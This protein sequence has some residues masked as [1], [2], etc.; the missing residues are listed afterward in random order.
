MA[1]AFIDTLELFPRG[2]VFV[3]LG[4][5]IIVIA[6]IVQE[7]ITPYKIGEQLT[8]K[9]NVALALSI[10]GYYLGVIAVYI[11]ALF[12][13]FGSSVIADGNL[14]FTTDY[15]QGVLEVF[16]YALVGIAV[17]NISR[18]VVDKVVLYQF[19]TE[20]EIIH[21]HNVGTGVVEFAVYVA[22][23]LIIAG[24]IA[25]EGGGPENS[26]AFFGL[27]LATLILYTL[28]YELTTPFKIHDEIENNNVAVGVALAANL[29]AFYY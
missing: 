21:D 7:L 29:I 25:G 16:I 17:L 9:D 12:Q 15:W 4:I 10:S 5:G 22:L 8:H 28:F 26:F 13:P 19:S 24:S 14:G 1:D 6:K 11:G 2:L 20:D 23:G 27:G 3:G 18:I